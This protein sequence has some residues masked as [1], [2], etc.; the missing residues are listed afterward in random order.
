MPAPEY[1]FECDFDQDGVYTDITADVQAFTATRGIPMGKYR[2]EAGV[3]DL[4][5]ANY[6]HKYSPPLSTSVLYP[7]VRPG[8]TLRCYLAYPYDALD[9]SGTAELNGRSVPND[10]NFGTWTA[11]SQFQFNGSNKID[12]DT[13]N[14][15]AQAYI[16]FGESDVW[17]GVKVERMV[18]SNTK[19]F[20]S[21]LCRYV[22]SDN[23]FL[24]GQDGQAT[25]NGHI[26]LWVKS[27]GTY[28]E[29][30]QEQLDFMEY[31]PA[32]GDTMHVV[33]HFYG[34]FVDVYVNNNRLISKY[35][36]STYSA[37]NGTNFGIATRDA[38]ISEEVWWSF[39]GWRPYFEGRIDEVRPR[40]D[41]RRRYAYIRCYDDMERAQGH[42][43]H[44]RA[45]TAPNTT[46]EIVGT[47]LDAMNVPW[48]R[49][50]YTRPDDVQL[51]NGLDDGLTLTQDSNEKVLD[52]DALTELYQVADDDGGG[53]VLPDGANCWAYHSSVHREEAPFVE[54]RATWSS[55]S[56]QPKYISEPVEWRSGK[57][58][59]ENEIFYRWKKF[60][61]G[62]IEEVWRLVETNDPDAAN[63]EFEADPDGS[64]LF[65][66]PMDFMVIGSGDAYANP[67]PL[68][69]TT[70]ILIDG[71]QDGT[72]PDQEVSIDSNVGTVSIN[73]SNNTIDDTG[74]DWSAAGGT[75]DG[76]SFS[77]AF[78]GI[79]IQDAT[80]RV[81]WAFLDSSAADPDGD[82]T[83]IAMY[84]GP[85]DDADRALG[86]AAEED[87]FDETDTPLTYTCH[88]FVPKFLAGY[89]G[90]FTV[91]RIYMSHD[92]VNGSG[93]ASSGSWLTFARLR[94]LKGTETVE[95]S[96]RIE[97]ATSAIQNGRYRVDHA[98]KHID[99]WQK[100]YDAAVIRERVRNSP[101]ERV[102]VSMPNGSMG[103]LQEII[104]RDISDKI[105]LD[106]DDFGV[107]GEYFITR[108]GL[109]VRN[110]LEI[111]CTWD[112]ER[113]GNNVGWSG[114]DL[115]WDQFQWSNGEW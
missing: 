41:T 78:R 32:A 66:K 20:A 106:Y 56:D 110:G 22:D 87:G 12:G 54:N 17:V 105:T 111:T 33:A 57:E 43:T 5:V 30:T 112:L 75:I 101:K 36:I 52:R 95:S 31:E 59:V 83:R 18:S 46:G 50:G 114:A 91:L 90:N 70:D 93:S 9:D 14:A 107:S 79:C 1:L 58:F 51:T 4:T 45:P 19:P 16:D 3:L 68:V 38:D 115:R 99:R 102:R 81:A 65:C 64:S 98:T 8:P 60:S 82:Q 71:E 108:V 24:I 88:I 47:I 84:D 104:N 73:T 86:Y 25:P 63:P 28:T 26:Q 13:E 67:R 69:P 11:A 113:A 89:D 37:I 109:E 80:G 39:G 6:N 62:N 94:A 48:V 74:Q 97:N 27:G 72:G 44:R 40:P 42:I 23:F 96:A 7:Y 53:L 61:F 100:A 55:T 85:I 35:D 21:L 34:D 10:S 49:G 76:V 92:F 15:E 29:L 2:A 77:A 103:N